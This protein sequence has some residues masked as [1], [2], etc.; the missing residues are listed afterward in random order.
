MTRDEALYREAASFEGTDHSV[1]ITTHEAPRADLNGGRVQ[2]LD[3]LA[4][5]DQVTATGL[6]DQ[7]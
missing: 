1:L 3:A 6:F 4:I 7:R 5:D 2:V